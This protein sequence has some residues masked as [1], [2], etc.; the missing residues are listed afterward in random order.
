MYKRYMSQLAKTK[1]FITSVLFLVLWGTDTL[2]SQSTQTVR[3]VVLNAETNEP[4]PTV[5]VYVSQTTVGTTTKNDG[6][7]ELTTKL[8]GIHT[9]VF[10]YIGYKTQTKE[11][12]FYTDGR[13]YF[14]I[15]LESESVELETLEVSASNKEW[16]ENYEIFIKNFI[17]E[18][19]AA[20]YTEIENSWVISFER[21]ENENLVAQAS[22]PLEIYNFSLGYEIRVDLVEFKWP[23]NG[24]PGYYLFYANY[25]E[26]ETESNRQKRR[27]RN[28][29]RDVY[30]GSF[31]H[32]LKSLYNDELRD[33]RFDTVLPNTHD[34]I[35]INPMESANRSSL[36]MFTNV[37]GLTP[38]NVKMYRLRFPVD[39][40][41]GKRWSNT[42]RA[43]SRITPMARG[44]VIIV[45]QDARLANPVSVRLDGAWS[46][47]RFANLLP[48]D[49]SPE[50]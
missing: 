39:V 31:E 30:L 33:N 8:S 36:R 21:D 47:H 9:L 38:Q 13:P 34:T 43:R 12:N 6:T 49:Y 11:L 18:T 1:V 24:D 17:G 29:R 5:H 15:K 48:E 26:I 4:I 32:F 14:E 16:S 37:S 46:S 22:Q 27:W 28:N 20:L 44:G 35:E 45:T 3:G 2:L 40:L 25:K 7:F 19:G 42:D 23:N 41:Y 50:E 10:S